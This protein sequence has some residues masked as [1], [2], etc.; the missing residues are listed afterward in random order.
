[1]RR[2]EILGMAEVLFSE[3]GTVYAAR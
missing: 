2:K 3:Q 1:V